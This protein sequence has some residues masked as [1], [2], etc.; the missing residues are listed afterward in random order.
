[1]IRSNCLRAALLA[2]ALSQVTYP[3]YA[4]KSNFSWSYWRS[5]TK[6]QPP[7]ISGSPATTVI[8]GSA[9][10]FVP[11]ASDPE[12]NTL[13]FIIRNKPTWAAFDPATG[14]L[15][16]T[17]KAAN[18]GTTSGITIYVTD[19]KST[20]SLPRFSITVK[21]ATSA[22][23]TPSPSPTPTPTP[24]PTN[25]PPA[26]S[27]SPLA[28]VPEGV[29]YSFQ[30]T[31]SDANGDTLTFT[32]ANRPAW[33]TFNSNTG[34]LV[35]TPA[36][37]SAGTYANIAI[38]VSDGKASA[39]L[40]PFA[41]TVTSANSAPTISG[42]PSTSAT[43][44]AAYSFAPS[45]ADANGD[46][47]TFSIA[48]KPSWASFSSS[49]GRLQGTPTATGSTSNIV[50][51]VTDGK[52][53]AQLPAFSIAVGAGAN[54]APRI[55][56]TPAGSVLQGSA[57]AFKPTAS[58]A[59]GDPLT[60]SIANK[61]GW[62]TFSASTGQLTGTPSAADVGTTAGIVISVSDGQA[63]VSLPAFS[64]AVQ[65]SATG[66]ATLTWQ[67]PTQNTDGT[68]LTNLGGYKVYWGTSQSNLAS[69]AT[70]S[71][72]G[73]TSY[74]VTGLVPGTYY[75]ALTATTPTGAESAKSNLAS[76]TVN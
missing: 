72:P 33:A 18:V 66:S 51:S 17:P 40:A 29:R 32:I 2:L 59:D 13:R 52:A 39:S 63:T 24:T 36:A 23:P 49:S 10:R 44:G 6:N 9:Y 4:Q 76:K 37:G 14:A 57:Y 46:T 21:S 68:P 47:L 75:F 16:G 67:P 43:V 11:T 22:T 61:P 30:P 53:S 35:G 3:A 31:A 74:V 34:A 73:L 12:G 48:N 62:A 15:Q 28:T 55:S 27:G 5:P 38:V 58:D 20:V 60:F 69:S 65:A 26:I 71:N 64:I 70:L 45:A 41:I 56:G 8:A 19:G 25:A 54:A 1:M 42:S 7:V 50:I